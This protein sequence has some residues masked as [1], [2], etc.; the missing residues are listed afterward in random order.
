[1]AMKWRNVTKTAKEILPLV[2]P[3]TVVCVFDTETTG[4]PRK[5]KS[6]KIIQFSAI[7]IKVH[8]G[9]RF[10][11]LDFL[12]LYINPKE[13]LDGKITQITGITDEMLEK[14]ADERKAASVIFGYLS[15]SDV[16]AAYNAPYDIA[17]LDEMSVRTHISTFPSPVIDVLVMSR[18]WLMKGLDVEDNRLEST[19]RCLYPD[20]SIRF[21]TAIEDVRATIQVME[22]LIPKYAAVIDDKAD[23]PAGIKKEMV[24]EKA[25]GWINP[26]NPHQQRI[27]LRLTNGN[28]VSSGDVF[29]DV[30]EKCWSHKST[31]QAK[32]LF[33]SL[34][35]ADI[36]DRVLKM[37]SNQYCTY[38]TMDELGKSRISWLREAQKKS[39][40]K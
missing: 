16:W 18:D 26:H 13:S 4:L 20:G 5:G 14:A 9:Y 25:Y 21:H 6:V 2:S 32:K 33:A 31:T 3:D 34:D 28:T 24:L 19:Y 39:K 7:R 35:L 29:Y 36:E 17:M 1:M 38:R 11:E 40:P 12:D 30:V 27:C 22:A 37:S 8:D 23:K 10:E 15:K